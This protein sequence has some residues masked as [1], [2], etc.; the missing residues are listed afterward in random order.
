MHHSRVVRGV[1]AAVAAILT[2]ALMTGISAA[3][4][5]TLT[6]L[7]EANEAA[8]LPVIAAFEAANPDI[9]V[10]YQQIPFEDLNAAVES[11]I[12]QGDS[13]IDVFAADTPR[14]PAFASRGYL[15]DVEA[16]RAR[17]E[18]AVPSRIEIDQVSH[19]GKIY[20]FP[21]QTSTQLLFYNR[22]LL[23]KAGIE[24]PGSSADRR[25]TWAQLVEMAGQAQ[26]AGARWGFMFQQVDRYY[27]LQPLFESAGAGSGLTGDDFLRPDLVNEKW[28][29]TAEW[30][31][32]LF[33]SG[34]APRGVA[35]NQTDDLF[36][37]GDVAFFV[38]GPWII[39][40]FE[41]AKELNYGVAPV[42]YFEGGKPVTPTG[43]WALAINPQAANMAAAR[44]FVE[45]ATLTTAGATLTVKV[46]PLIP[47]HKGAFE[48]YAEQIGALTPKVGPAM[49]IIAYET[50]TTAVFRPRSVGY[51][52][53]ETVMTRVFSDIRNGA[54][55][56]TALQE[57]Q[58]QLT[59]ALARLR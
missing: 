44:R 33:E 59:A 25:L 55:A 7:A 10:Q 42:P 52:A 48:N 34:L 6:V 29:E 23:A 28:V 30:Y 27:Q 13:S 18:E 58:D 45:F 16:D 41:Q 20:A 50:G 15:V 17:I 39:P 19:G 26:S 40:R 12:G 11:R 43:A 2:T 57:A 5:T 38:G 31:G 47:V 21:M 9:D 3:Q 22:D 8:Y 4:Q 46:T 54:D 51:V 49:D 24:E 35:A 1:S 53:F 36:F 14:I 37:N 32:E 56:R